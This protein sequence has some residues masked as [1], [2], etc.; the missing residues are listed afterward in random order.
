M[1]SSN[2]LRNPT[3]STRIYL[4]QTYQHIKCI[5]ISTSQSTGFNCLG[6]VFLSLSS[7]SYTPPFSPIFLADH[8]YQIF[9]TSNLSSWNASHRRPG[10]VFS[11][12]PGSVLASMCLYRSMCNSLTLVIIR[13]CHLHAYYVTLFGNNQIQVILRHT[14]NLDIAIL[15]MVAY[16][17]KNIH[18]QVP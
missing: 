4:H 10:D 18:I 9:A 13:K 16:Q 7:L 8:V 1:S 6:L 17:S 2:C 5:N 12:Y 15:P 11:E 3:I 14:R